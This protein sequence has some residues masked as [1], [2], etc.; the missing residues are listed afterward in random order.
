MHHAASST[1]AAL[2]AAAFTSIASGQLAI[3][4]NT[5]TGDWFNPSN[6]SDGVPVAGDTVWIHNGGTVEIT[7]GATE[8]CG[9]VVIG[10]TGASTGSLVM[11][12]GTINA[13]HL[14]F[15]NGEPGYGDITGASSVINVETL[16]LNSAYSEVNFADGTINASIYVASGWAAD[17][18]FSHDSGTI[19]TP[20]VIVGNIFSGDGHYNLMDG[21]I[22]TGEIRIGST[23]IGEFS[24]YGGEINTDLLYIGTS[25]GGQG[26]YL[27]L[28]GTLNALAV[29]RNAM[30]AL[31]VFNFMD[32][33]LN[34]GTFGMFVSMDLTCQ[35]GTLVPG[36]I[37]SI[38][39]STVNGTLDLQLPATLAVDVNGSVDADQVVVNDDVILKGALDVNLLAA[40]ATTSSFVVVDHQDAG[41]IL[42][43]F[44][45]ILEGGTVA[46]SFGG[47]SY[48]FAVSY[49]GG[50]GNDVV[51][52]AC[53][54]DA[55]GDGSIDFDDLNLVLINWGGPGPDGDLDGSGLVDFDDLNLVL[56][57]WDTSCV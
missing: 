16:V 34:V 20:L 23:G 52:G 30:A 45:G 53:F 14:Q 35:G 56:S 38:G 51:I 18:T 27:L 5:G 25:F 22:N 21:E 40:P 32:G 13:D 3:W 2:L 15:A 26:E 43:T 8:T 33:V 7:G 47:S 28:G 42:G 1:F 4:E 19:N 44:D 37:G 50:D 31:S 46:A 55:T 17:C 10:Q 11:T 49:V 29:R 24:Q 48:N 9:M 36:G 41:P 12:G 39:T 6:W 54:G 57:L